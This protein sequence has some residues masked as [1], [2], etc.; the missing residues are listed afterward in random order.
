MKETMTKKFGKAVYCQELESFFPSISE[1][2]RIVGVNKGSL[3]RHLNGQTK[4][5]VDIIGILLKINW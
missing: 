4:L 5:A 3:S 2:A 1:A